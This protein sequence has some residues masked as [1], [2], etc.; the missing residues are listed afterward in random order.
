[1]VQDADDSSA[2]H[3]VPCCSEGKAM[4]PGAGKGWWEAPGEILPLYPGI[5]KS[6]LIS[7]EISSSIRFIVGQRYNF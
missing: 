7:Q 2:S 6:V 5:M 4:R 1:M 3:I